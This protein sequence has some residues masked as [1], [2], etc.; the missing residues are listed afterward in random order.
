MWKFS[1]LGSVFLE[2]QQ[3]LWEIAI[4]MMKNIGSLHVNEGN[5]RERNPSYNH[6]LMLWH[7]STFPS[8]P[9]TIAQRVFGIAKKGIP[10]AIT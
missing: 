1:E 4:I 8:L 3:Q 6:L 5:E 2:G 7:V 9:W 10:Y